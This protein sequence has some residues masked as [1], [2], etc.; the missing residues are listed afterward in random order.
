L[1]DINS[2]IAK[3]RIE[4]G[5]VG[6]SFVDSFLTDG[7]TN[8]FLTHHHPLDGA[9]IRVFVNGTDVSTLSAVEESTGTLVLDFTAN[10]FPTL[11]TQGNAV[12]DAGLQV[13]VS[14][15]EFRYFTTSELTDLVNTAFEQ[16]T[17]HAVDAMG[18]KKTLDNLPTVEE[19]PVAVYATTLALYTL[20][21]DAAFDIDISAPDGVTIP[22][23][24]RF[25]QLTEQIQTRRE[26]YRDLCA[27]LGVGL[28]RIEVENLNRISKSTNR[29]IPVYRPQEVDDR[30]YPQ[31]VRVDQPT[32]GDESPAWDNTGTE[33]TA[34]QGQ[35]FSATIPLPAGD[36][37]NKTFEAGLYYQRGSYQVL[38]TFGLSVVVDNTGTYQATLT[39]TASQT[40]LMLP[41][42]LYYVVTA[43]DNTTNEVTEVVSAN[44]YTVHSYQ[45]IL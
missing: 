15:T 34:Y 41:E 39:L 40:H 1:A 12:P 18:R 26:Q 31:R 17:A 6:T 11:F 20:S 13:I 14:G 30:S 37:T 32:F 23:A 9:S 36:Y 43:T 27:Q 19:Y 25:R 5:D 7:K 2:L 24:E 22:R 29:L 21:T 3:T 28:Y 8:R 42:R 4:L 44:F 38:Q 33:L 35:A 10:D 16:H 45:V